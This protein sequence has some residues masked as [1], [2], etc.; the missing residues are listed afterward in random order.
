MAARLPRAFAALRAGLIH[1]VHLR[2]LEEEETGIL[3]AQ[4]AARADALLAGAAAGMTYGE[5]R[6]AARKLVLKLDPDAARAKKDAARREAQVRRFREDS[7]NAGM[8]ARE[9]PCDEVL[10]SWQHV[11]QRALDLRAAGPP[12]RLAASVARGT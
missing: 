1:P 7:G 4:D 11:E 5:F 9:L 2:I 10:A 6:S 3:P 12:A 8:V